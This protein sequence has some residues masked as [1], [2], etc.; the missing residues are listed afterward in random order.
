M[1]KNIPMGVSQSS[2]NSTDDL[3]VFGIKN[4]ET[5]FQKALQELQLSNQQPEF[6]KIVVFNEKFQQKFNYN[7][8][9]EGN[10]KVYY[11]SRYTIGDLMS[12]NPY[13]FVRL[14]QN[15]EIQIMLLKKFT[16][17]NGMIKLAKKEYYFDIFNKNCQV[18]FDKP[19]NTDKFKLTGKFLLKFEDSEYY[20]S[21]LFQSYIT[22]KVQGNLKWLEIQ[23]FILIE[24]LNPI[25]NVL[26]K[27]SIDVQSL[28]IYEKFIYFSIK[29]ID[30]EILFFD[31]NYQINQ[32]EIFEEKKLKFIGLDPKGKEWR[33]IVYYDAQDKYIHILYKGT[34]QNLKDLIKLNQGFDFDF[35]EYSEAKIKLKYGNL[36][37]YEIKLYQLSSYI[38][39][40]ISIN[41][42]DSQITLNFYE[43]IFKFDNKV[44]KK[45]NDS[46]ELK[47]SKYEFFKHFNLD[48]NIDVTLDIHYS[49]ISKNNHFIIQGEFEKLNSFIFI[50]SFI[51]KKFEYR[52]NGVYIYG[53]LHEN[54]HFCFPDAHFKFY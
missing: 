44:L 49:F 16:T 27:N 7:Q 2:D 21:E 26:E 6:T 50:Y 17:E 36:G 35:I 32:V 34:Y 14:F 41:I 10:E 3:T 33:I 29:Y 24:E 25:F 40:G 37:F 8:M 15:L 9:I 5:V 42:N 12:D 43:Y 31:Q 51:T 20:E 52:E 30:K 28:I 46:F 47:L 48:I 19:L 54:Y 1:D 45:V 23:K 22:I 39:K 53:N 38:T 13:L 18:I 11:C 4:K